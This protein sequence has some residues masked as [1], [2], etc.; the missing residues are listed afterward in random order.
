LVEEGITPLVGNG[1]R[2]VRT[3]GVGE[4][5]ALVAMTLLVGDERGLDEL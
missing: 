5:K 2:I 1:V 4:D 3:I